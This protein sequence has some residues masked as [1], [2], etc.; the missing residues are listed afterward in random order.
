MGAD[1]TR[2]SLLGI[3]VAGVAEQMLTAGLICGPL[4]LHV[5]GIPVCPREIHYE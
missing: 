5:M 4:P 1:Y 3:P 2:F